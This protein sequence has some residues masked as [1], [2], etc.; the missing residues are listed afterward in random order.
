[1]KGDLKMSIS[2]RPM[3][4][5]FSLLG[6]LVIASSASKAAPKE[7]EKAQIA[8][9]KREVAALQLSLAAARKWQAEVP[10]SFNVNKI[11][12]A[13]SAAAGVSSPTGVVRKP[14]ATMVIEGQKTV[15]RVEVMDIGF[16]PHLQ[17]GVHLHPC[18]VVGRVTAGKIL[19]QIEGQPARTLKTG[20]TF[21]EPAN[22]EILHFDSNGDAPAAFTAY[23]LLGKDD[24][25]LVTMLSSD[26][27]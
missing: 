24:H 5:F 8:R 11:K 16:P 18:P 19:F 3:G 14:L 15:D 23:Y 25:Q 10:S 26:Q 4:A 9:L 27:K 1:M 13:T 6:C 12:P 22:V 21:F 20:D 7:P 2:T 17:P